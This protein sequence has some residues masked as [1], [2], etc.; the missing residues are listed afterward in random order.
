MGEGRQED[1]H[2]HDAAERRQASERTRLDRFAGELETRLDKPSI[3]AALVTPA[4]HRL[5]RTEY[6]NAIRDL[7]ALDVN[8][9]ALL[10]ADGSSQ[11]FDNLAEALARRRL[12]L[13]GD[14]DQPPGGR[15]SHRP[16]V[17]D[18]VCPAAGLAQDRHIEGHRSARAAAWCSITFPLD[19]D[20]SSRSADAAPARS[21]SI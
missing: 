7:L 17:A 9:N 10:P 13:G 8:V 11:G 3:T 12:R 6:A 14:E 19:A 15:R 20:A 21:G 2:G 16:A 18:D 4:L 5:N 1:P